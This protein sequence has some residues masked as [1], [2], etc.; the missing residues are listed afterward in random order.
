MLEIIYPDFP[1]KAIGDVRTCPA[2]DILPVIDENSFVVGQ[3]SRSSVH[4][5]G[6]LHPVVHLHIIDRFSRI[7][8]QKR[9]LKKD[10]YPGLWDTAVGGHVSYGESLL[11]SLFREAREELN[12]PDFNPIPVES[13]H[14]C[15]GTDKEI[16]FIFAAIGAFNPAPDKT[17][18]DDGRWWTGE[19]I[20]ENL[21]KG[22]FTTQ[23]EAEYQRIKNKLEALL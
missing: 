16:A 14:Y 13:H 5:L 2:A 12:L 19:E 18:V 22:V 17:E 4:T 8:I 1:A 10:M 6:L 9:S 3:A 15:T 20:L 21:G 11:E 7:Y 23:F